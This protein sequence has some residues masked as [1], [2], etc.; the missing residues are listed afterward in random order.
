MPIMGVEAIPNAVIITELLKGMNLTEIPGGGRLPQAFPNA[1][2]SSLLE[3]S[4]TDEAKMPTMG[5]A[6]IP[7]AVIITELLK[8]MN[9]TEAPGHG[10][11][12]EAFP[13]ASKH[14]SSLLEMQS[15]DSR[16][17]T[18]GVAA[19]SNAVIITEL[20]KGLNL[21]EVPGHGQLPEDFPKASMPSLLSKGQHVQHGSPELNEKDALDVLAA[22][23]AEA[24]R[25]HKAAKMALRTQR[26]ATV[27]FI[28]VSV[29]AVCIL[30]LHMQ[31]LLGALPSLGHM[32]TTLGFETKPGKH[33]TAEPSEEQAPNSNNAM[34]SESTGAQNACV[35]T[36][37]VR[38]P[39]SLI[40]ST[41]EDTRKPVSF[42]D[43]IEERRKKK[44]IVKRLSSL[45]GMGSD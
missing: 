10:K 13:N 44:P 5:V 27:F 33:Q 32:L 31:G 18:M 1:S 14:K 25:A 24:N 6:A 9:L 45:F 40:T 3:R 36:P 4:Q 15:D 34:S 26:T 38:N 12:P 42:M 39:E 23:T 29:I 21:S 30:L 16:M 8:R 19:I 17:P 28:I 22:S 20:L 2:M 43:M 7:N 35:G 41:Q 37:Y 11:L